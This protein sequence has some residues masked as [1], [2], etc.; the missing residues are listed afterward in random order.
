MAIKTEAKVG[1]A[2]PATGSRIKALI[3]AIDAVVDGRN[4]GDLTTAFVRIL[5]HASRDQDDASFEAF[6]AQVV[7]LARLDRA[8][9]AAADAVAVVH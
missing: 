8:H 5:V 6:M 9:C 3:Q 1:V 4:V 7:M 2:D